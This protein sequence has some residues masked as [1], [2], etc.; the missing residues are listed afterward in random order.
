MFKNRFRILRPMVCAL[1]L[2]LTI[3]SFENAA[4][5]RSVKAQTAQ[6]LGGWM[7]ANGLNV[8][9]SAHS[10]TLLNDGRIL[11]AGGLDNAN[12][13]LKSTE[14]YDPAT[15]RST[16]V[17]DLNEARSD[18]HAMALKDGRVLVLNKQSAETFNPATGQWTLTGPTTLQTSSTSGNYDRAS[19]TLLANGKVLVT[20]GQAGILTFARNGA[21]LF[22]PATGKWMATGAMN[23]GRSDHSTTLLPSG[24]VLA[25]GGINRMEQPDVTELYDP[26]TGQWTRTGRMRVPRYRHFAAY[27]PNG[28]VLVAGGAADLSLTSFTLTGRTAELYDPMTGVWVLAEALSFS[29]ATTRGRVAQ[30]SDGRVLFVGSGELYD[31]NTGRWTFVARPF[32]VGSAILTALPN[33]KALLTGGSSDRPLRLVQQFDPALSPVPIFGQWSLTS[34]YAAGPNH[35]ATAL[36]DGKIL[37]TGG[38]VPSAITGTFLAQSVARMFDTKDGWQTVNNMAVAR[39]RHTVT[40]LPNGHVLAVGGES[41]TNAALSGAELFNPATKAWSAAASLSVPRQWHQTVLLANGKVL[42][43]GGSNDGGTLSSA[44]LYDPAMDRWTST[45]A[46]NVARRFHTLTVLA[47]GKVLAAGGENNGQARPSAELYDPATGNWRT[48]ADMATA[49]YRHTATRLLNGKVLMVGG[50]NSVS[51]FNAELFDPTTEQWTATGTL[52]VARRNHSATL[53]DN[54]CVLIAGGADSEGPLS[55]AELFDPMAEGGVGAFINTD[56]LRR[57]RDS[58]S[59]IKLSDGMVLA[60]S[61]ATSTTQG[62]TVTQQVVPEAELFDPNFR[63]QAFVVPSRFAA[64]SASSYRG[65][66]LASGSIIAIFG[67]GFSNTTAV[68]SSTPL[69]TTLAGARVIITRQDLSSPLPLFFVSPNQINAQLLNSLNNTMPLGMITLTVTTS[70]GRTIQEP[71]YAAPVAPG[72]FSADASGKGVAAA[73]ALR[74]KANGEQVYEP[75]ARFDPAQNRIVAVPLDLSNPNELVFLI[76]YGTGWRSRSSLS[77]VTASVG[78]EAV[79]VT[80]AGQQ[81]DFVGL[82][83]ANLRLPNAL[84]GRGEVEVRLTVDSIAANAVTVVVK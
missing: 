17:G 79:E 30:L 58:H 3:G 31:F 50:D 8:G 71:I 29:H 25:V 35:A 66:D 5:D 23:F 56:S 48:V 22:D 70:D 9:R 19:V 16:A 59:A 18:H 67:E 47:N 74:I 65:G 64:V 12:R 27:L 21:E 4:E 7:I 13:E 54:G 39:H 26:E 46:M 44:E 78:G 45:G 61:G 82:D 81:N 84:T 75:I 1:A 49:R 53:L 68:A 24:K 60:V 15:G 76:L 33:G 62:T 80:Y 55:S 6:L 72:V 14:I 73:V 34:S 42:V 41:V 52:L 28:R 43:A 38:A 36:A 63:S 57:R 83:Q 40:L 10:A 20:G 69:P 51:L 32:D 2:I 11:I 37:V 77:A